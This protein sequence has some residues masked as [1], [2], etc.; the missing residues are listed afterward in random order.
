[1][2]AAVAFDANRFDP[3]AVTQ[4]VERHL[5]KFAGLFGHSP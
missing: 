5:P 3:A 4:P 1:M 2:S